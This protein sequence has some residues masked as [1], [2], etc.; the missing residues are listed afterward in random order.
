MFGIGKESKKVKHSKIEVK[1]IESNKLLEVNDTELK[2]ELTQDKVTIIEKEPQIVKNKEKKKVKLS[3][4]E[5]F[6]F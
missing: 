5:D 1:P 3:T 4:P 6:L 2:E